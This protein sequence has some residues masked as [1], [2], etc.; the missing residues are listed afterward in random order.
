MPDATK[1]AP[2]PEA[3]IDAALDELDRLL[4]RGAYYLAPGQRQ[5]FA[6]LLAVVDELLED[7]SR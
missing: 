3:Q 4:G 5:S 6:E 7:V 1:R 2:A